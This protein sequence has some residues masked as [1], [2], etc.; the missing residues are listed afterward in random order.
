MRSFGDPN[1][2]KAPKVG[3]ICYKKHVILL[4]NSIK[5]NLVLD[6]LGLGN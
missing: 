4:N 5:T 6:G 1:T 2:K 3:K